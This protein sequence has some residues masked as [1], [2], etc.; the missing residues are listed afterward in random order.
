METILIVIANTIK[1][2]HGKKQIDEF[3]FWV[4]LLDLNL[5]RSEQL[6]RMCGFGVATDIRIE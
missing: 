4:G 1:L 6:A 5:T 3:C 2:T